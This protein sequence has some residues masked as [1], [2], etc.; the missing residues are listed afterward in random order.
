M[1]KL[2]TFTAIALMLTGAGTT[3]GQ[4]TEEQNTNQRQQQQ[5]QERQRTQDQNRQRTR[6]DTR[7]QGSVESSQQVHRASN[8][9][10][11]DVTTPNQE[12]TIGDIEDL[13]LDSQSGNI[14]YAAISVGGFLGIGDKLV[15]VP[16]N[17]INVQQDQEGEIQ[18][19]LN[20]SRE[21]LEQAPGFDEDNWPNFADRQWSQEN[22][23]HY[24]VANQRGSEERRSDRRQNQRRTPQ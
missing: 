24:R 20:M 10:G 11:M 8:V 2:T 18:L 17:S 14:R 16:W 23:R 21:Q 12:D 1:S 6:R 15:A 7:R 19:T 3:L 9:I 22:D 13:V 5:V 4:L